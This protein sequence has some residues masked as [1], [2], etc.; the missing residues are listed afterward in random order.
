[1]VVL[2]ITSLRVG[3]THMASVDGFGNVTDP[4]TGFSARPMEGGRRGWSAL[5]LSL[6]GVVSTHSWHPDPRL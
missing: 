2:K 1:M 4:G 5:A 6:P 3:V